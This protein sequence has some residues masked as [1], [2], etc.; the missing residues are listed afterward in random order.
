MPRSTSRLPRPS[1]LAAAIAAA[2]AVAPVSTAAAAPAP[3]AVGAACAGTLFQPFTA[4]GDSSFYSLLPDGDF[5]AG[6]QGWTFTRGAQVDG[7]GN[8]NSHAHGRAGTL[9]H[10]VI[11][12]PGGSATS[13][14][15]CVGS[16]SP[17]ARMFADTV[18]RSRS[19]GSSLQVEILLQ[20]PNG[21]MQAKGMGRVPEIAGWDA[22]RRMSIAQGQLGVQHT[23][24]T[25]TIRFRFTAIEGSTW[26]LDDIYLDPRMRG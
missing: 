1:V 26:R 2:A 14:P 17:Y 8:G 6:G 5:E 10:S 9:T 4:W 16:A 3:A 11:L 18:R 7:A 22:T 20:S 15:V 19:T 12:P 13:P 23:S 21:S 25:T 24:Y